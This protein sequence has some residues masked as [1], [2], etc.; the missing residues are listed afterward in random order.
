MTI[1]PSSPATIALELLSRSEELQWKVAVMM[2][3]NT[4]LP[5]T[6]SISL[7]PAYTVWGAYVAAENDGYG[8]S[9]SRYHMTPLPPS[10]TPPR[11]N[12]N[13]IR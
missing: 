4:D 3:M 10:Y 1:P 12:S 11:Y 7:C 6:S 9:V 8:E 2:M 13:K 5:L